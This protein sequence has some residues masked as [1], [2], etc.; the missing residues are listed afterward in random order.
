MIYFYFSLGNSEHLCLGDV[1]VPLKSPLMK[2]IEKM[3]TALGCY[4]RNR[5]EE[6]HSVR[7]FYRLTVLDSPCISLCMLM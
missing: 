6:S 3:D 2:Y 1:A 5:T 7:D 4:I